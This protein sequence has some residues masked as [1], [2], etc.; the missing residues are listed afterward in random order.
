M[1]RWAKIAAVALA[2][3]WLTSAPVWAQHVGPRP[4]VQQK[5][6]AKPPKSTQ[7][8][9]ENK[10]ARQA[11]N[12]APGHA[13]D[14]LRRYKDLPP[15]QQR[16][17]L[18]NDPDFKKLPPHR[19]AQLLQRLQNFS[20]LPPRQQQRILN[21]M[22]TWEHLTPEQKRQRNQLNRQIRELP[23][24][25]RLL[26]IKTIRGMRD[27]TPE[28]REQLLNSNDFKEM[29]SDHERDLLG[30]AARLPLAPADGGQAETPAQ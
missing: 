11:E 1:L 20:S 13:G 10:E 15:D 12:A 2:A 7:N 25:R 6:A 4:R 19:Q 26:L 18:E 17:A 21:R 30:G 28:Q 5:P 29:F 14:W 27:L 22:E 9:Q 24:E 3:L 8:Q 16:Q 23:L